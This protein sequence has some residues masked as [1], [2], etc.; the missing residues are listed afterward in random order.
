[1]ATEE[2]PT[3]STLVFSW[4]IKKKREILCVI[5]RKAMVISSECQGVGWGAADVSNV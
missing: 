5:M 1:M 4:L 2:R 3:R